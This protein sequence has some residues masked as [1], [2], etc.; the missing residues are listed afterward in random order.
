MAHD[1]REDEIN[2]L[3]VAATRALQVLII[4]TALELVLQYAK[5]LA[6]KQAQQ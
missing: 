6:Y 4:N 1:A 5:G 3:Y 2:L